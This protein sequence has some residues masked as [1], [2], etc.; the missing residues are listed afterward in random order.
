MNS[1][2]VL[3]GVIGNQKVIYA[4]EQVGVMEISNRTASVYDEEE[5]TLTR[6]VID[7]V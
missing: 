3:E 1:V 2:Y 6:R 5:V 7:V 4:D